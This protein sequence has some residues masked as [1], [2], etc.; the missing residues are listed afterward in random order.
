MTFHDRPF[1]VFQTSGFQQDMV[2]NADFP[3]IVHVAGVKNEVTEFLVQSHLFRQ[4][5]SV[6]ADSLYM[7]ASFVIAKFR[8]A[9]KGEYRFDERFTQRIGAQVSH[10][11]LRD[12]GQPESP[13]GGRVDLAWSR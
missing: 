12:C 10:E 11:R 4:F 6:T 1:G 5:L 3:D 7:L 2:G 9:D 13:S 8:C